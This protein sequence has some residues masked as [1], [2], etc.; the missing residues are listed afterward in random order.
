MVIH[1]L[2]NGTM[3]KDHERSVETGHTYILRCSLWS[4][5]QKPLC[6]WFFMV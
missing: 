6:L 1:D 3:A 4:G 5:H 2:L